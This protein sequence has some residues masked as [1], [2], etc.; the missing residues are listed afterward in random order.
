M[1]IDSTCIF[2]VQSYIHVHE[3]YLDLHWRWLNRFIV[4]IILLR[5]KLCYVNGAN[6]LLIE[7]ESHLENLILGNSL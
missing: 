5:E 3:Y 7:R 6:W 1:S 4:V 2:V